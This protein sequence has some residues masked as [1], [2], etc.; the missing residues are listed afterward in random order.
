MEVGRRYGRHN[1]ISKASR[2][3]PPVCIV[4]DSGNVRSC[5]YGWNSE[6]HT[7]AVKNIRPET[8]NAEEENVQRKAVQSRTLTEKN[9]TYDTYAARAT[10]SEAL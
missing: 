6:A 2:T 1:G 10:T 3:S 4:R 5:L 7:H 9:S 8:N